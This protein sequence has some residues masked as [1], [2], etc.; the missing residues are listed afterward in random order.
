[1]ILRL[2]KLKTDLFLRCLLL[3]KI[4]QLKLKY[5]HLYYNLNSRLKNLDCLTKFVI[6]ILLRNVKSV[7]INSTESPE[8]IFMLFTM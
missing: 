8:L 6:L 3:L 2:D 4:N 5:L 1:M 7:K